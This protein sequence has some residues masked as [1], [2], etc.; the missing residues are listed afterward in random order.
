MTRTHLLPLV[1][2]AALA[3]CVVPGCSKAPEIPADAG[4][5]HIHHHH[6]PHGGTVV[7]LGEEEFH[8]ELLVDETGTKLQAF[9]L[10]SELE[11]FVRSSSPS[12]AITATAAG[13]T[14]DLV[15]AAVSN[16]ETGETVGDTSQF[17]ADADWLKATPRFDGVL[18]SI[19]V[20]GTT[21][22][23]VKFNFPKGNE[24]ER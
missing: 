15:L 21:Y 2:S 6:P 16:S 19:T 18:R 12:V 3:A 8:V 13:K 1:F 17:E 10:D 9:I 24:T 14:R 22:S 20:R 4:G 5:P 23:D 7:V 11:N